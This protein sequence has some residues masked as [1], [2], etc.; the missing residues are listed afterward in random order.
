MYYANIKKFSI[1]QQNQQN[2]S[3]T[4]NNIVI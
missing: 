1:V 4:I 3:I 2:Q